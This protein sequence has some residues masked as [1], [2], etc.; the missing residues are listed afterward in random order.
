MSNHPQPVRDRVL[1]KVEE[2]WDDKISL[3]NGIII[4]KETEYNPEGKVAITGTVAGVPKGG[5]SKNHPQVKHIDPIVEAG[6]KIY[7]H[8]LVIDTI[9]RM[10]TENGVYYFVDYDQIFCRIVDNQIQMVGDW[11]LCDKVTEKKLESDLIVLPDEYNLEE[12]KNTMVVRHAGP[13][14][15]TQTRVDITPGET[16]ITKDDC[17]FENEIEGER[18]YT[19]K[20]SDIIGTI[21]EL[22]GAD[23]A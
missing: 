21:S 19:V 20:R 7:F 4:Y 22:K 12:V 15:H 17:E 5:V 8:Y 2:E 10:V 11:V 6:D 18:Y 13:Q 14:P 3:G 1:V 23:T 9:N 16:V